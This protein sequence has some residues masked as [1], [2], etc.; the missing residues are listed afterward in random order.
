MAQFNPSKKNLNDFNNGEK[1]LNRV[2]SPNADDFNNVIESQLYVQE[3]T[4]ALTDAPDISQADNVGTPTVE[5]VANGNYKKFKFSNLKGQKGDT[6]IGQ[7]GKKG[8]SFRN[9]GA[10][11]IDTTYVNNDEFIDVVTY[12]GSSY[13]VKADKSSVIGYE[14]TNTN[15]WTLLAEKGQ[16]GITSSNIYAT[17]V[18]AVATNK[19]YAIKPKAP[20]PQNQNDIITCELNEVI[21]PTKTS[22]LHND[23]NFITNTV[24]NLANYYL[25]QEIYTREEVNNL[26]AQIKTISF[27]IVETLPTTGAS[28]IIYLKKIANSTFDNNIYDEFIWVNNAWEQIGSTAVDLS[29]YYKK[30]EVDGK[31]AL[32]A[33]KSEIPTKVGDLQNDKGFIDKSVSNLDNYYTKT[34]I[35]TDYATKGE[36]PTNNNQL[37]NGA[38]YITSSGSCASATNATN[39][40][41]GDKITDTYATKTELTNGLGTK[42]NTLTSQQITNISN[43]PNKADKSY[44]NDELAKKAN[45]NGGNTFSGLQTVN[46]PTNVAGQEQATAWFNTANGGRVGFGKEKDNSGT[47]IF[48][49]Q[50]KE[51]RRLNFRA[52]ATA[53]S[54]VWEQ[55]ESGAALY[56]DLHGYANR[57]SMP[58]NRG[59]GT[60]ALTKDITKSAVG[61]SNVANERQYSASNK[62]TNADVGLGNVINEKQYCSSNQPPYP[63]TSVN[64][65]TGAVNITIPT[66]PTN[67]ISYESNSVSVAGN[68][69]SLAKVSPQ[70]LF[71]PNG[72][73]MGGTA[74]SAGLVTRGI[75]GVTTPN[76]DGS[77]SKE[78]LYLNYD[79]DNNYTHRV[80]LGAGS[81]GSEIANSSPNASV[82]KARTL[83]AVRGDQM[84]AYCSNTY[85]TKGSVPDVSGKA[86]KSYVDDELAKKQ[87]NLSEEQLNNIA[88]VQ[89]KL[90]KSGG[91]MTGAITL[92]NG[93]GKGILMPTDSNINVAGTTNTILG[94]VGGTY[95][96]GHTNFNTHIRGIGMDI[97]SSGN[98]GITIK[99][100]STNTDYSTIHTNTNRAL[101]LQEGSSGIVNIGGT[102]STTTS[103]DM[104]AKLIVNGDIKENGKKLSEKYQAKLTA[105]TNITIDPDTNTISATGGGDV[106]KEYVDGELA[107]KAN[108]SGATFTGKVSCGGASMDTNG[109]VTG[110]WLKTT[111]SIHLGSAPANYPVLSSGWIYS[112]TADETKSDLGINDKVDKSAFVLDGTTL[113][114][115]I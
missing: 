105:G 50:V 39:D 29:D 69:K 32:K 89:N 62:P 101:F 75:T 2:D 10:Y 12:N 80:V 37:A 44:V 77:C 15:Y 102:P 26:I 48:F 106:T 21:V 4:E 79:G 42:Q 94:F 52:S 93:D 88:D 49:D 25:K 91:T 47:A 6:G 38:G 90:D 108:L 86:D 19:Q 36:I 17:N 63:V 43:V 28:N 99:G 20:L 114:I 87:D 70:A 11:N 7:Q 24:N 31:L 76:A 61:L 104:S 46:A 27:Q 103:Q 96:L 41:N 57:I 64:G 82:S 30:G 112:R 83:C 110:T 115:T 18:T 81:L 40:S 109:Y 51:T 3:Y 53:G 60:L 73:V 58:T 66:I 72:L 23:S 5:L 111:A 67:H 9:R 84:V 95:T 68:T 56:F 22:E 45:I 100:I 74:A 97:G 65:Q 34:K 14:P 1:F 107:K 55:P 92:A 13:C 113:T 54:I 35:D 33:D 59:Q 71:A 16:D 98:S 8:I 85:A 78:H